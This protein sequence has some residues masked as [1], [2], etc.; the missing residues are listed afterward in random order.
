MTSLIKDTFPSDFAKMFIGF[1][2][3]NNELAGFGPSRNY[4]PYNIIR[5]D[6]EHYSIEMAVAGF[7]PEK[8]SVTTKNGT[9]TVSSVTNDSKDVDSREYIYRGLASREFTLSF[10]LHENM[11][12]IGADFKN[13][14]LSVKVEHKI[15]D[16]MKPQTIAIKTPKD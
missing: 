2:L 16:Y 9:L 11:R 8:I 14:V 1:D 4:P 10:K 3:L 6:A 7:S 5:D 13:G 15:P 12:V